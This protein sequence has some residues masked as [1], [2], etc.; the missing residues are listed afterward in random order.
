[1]STTI[2]Q[3]RNELSFS[4]FNLCATT[5]R[6]LEKL[7]IQEPTPI[8]A[9]TIPALLDGRDV[10]GQARTG[11]GKT[12]AFVI[13][14]VEFAD[15]EHRAVQVLIMTPTRELAVQVN[16]VVGQIGGPR[17]L[18][19]ALVFGGRAAG[20]QIKAIRRGAQVVVGT[21]GRLLDLLNQ[22]ALRLDQVRMLVIDEADEML[23]RGFAPDVEKIIARTPSQRQTALFSATVPN[24][25][26][27]TAAA[28][29]H[30]PVVAKVDPR[31]EDSAVIDHLAF[32]VR[33]GE[34]LDALKELLDHRNGGSIIVFGRTKHG[35]NKLAN[36]LEKDGYPVGALQG[37]LSQ[38]ARDQ[39]M[40][41]FRTGR[42]QILVATNVAARGLDISNVDQVI[43]I[44]LPESSDLLTHR[45][46][47]TGRMGRKGQAITFL[48][49]GDRGKW[50][51]L[52]RG[53]GREIPQKPWP[54]AATVT[55]NQ[56]AV[57]RTTPAEDIALTTPG[58]PGDRQERR[59]QVPRTEGDVKRQRPTS[60]DRQRTHHRITCTDCGQPANVPFKP[61]PSRPVFCSDC[62]Q[63]AKSKTRRTRR[64]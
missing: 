38:N 45:I 46:G 53:L 13:P 48:E 56:A 43:N 8:Q 22:G 1:M 21:P 28:Y 15:P 55:G 9:Q 52:Q 58:E 24:W 34:K 62:F 61:D 39:V 41:Q 16:D 23:D 63:P 64:V 4:D 18:R 6:A 27:E 57:A 25:V 20:P 47:R 5:Y 59:R 29:L 17:G 33:K 26:N 31:P 37:N 35:V 50:R 3:T 44:E 14:A 51:Q 54:G 19:S 30:D 42:I 7:N 36:R 12:L 60:S 49:P 11:S 2:E 10:I 40:K 32:D